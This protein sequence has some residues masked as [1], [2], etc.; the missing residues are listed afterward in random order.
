MALATPARTRLKLRPVLT[1][2][3]SAR[4]WSRRLVGLGIAAFVIF[5]WVHALAPRDTL[6]RHYPLFLL[7]AFIAL[8]GLLYTAVFLEIFVHEAGHWF[9]GRLVGIRISDFV[10]GTGSRPLRFAWRGIRFS[11]GPWLRW[12]YVREIPARANLAF[13]KQ[14]VFLS[15]GMVAVG[16]LVAALYLVPADAYAPEPWL[17]TFATLRRFLFVSSLLG[18]AASA[19]PRECRIEGALTPNDALLIRQA[20]QRRGREDAHWREQEQLAELARLTGAGNY[21][22]A[23]TVL[24]Q[25]LETNPGNQDWREALATSEV[26]AKDWVAVQRR[27]RETIEQAAPGSAER[28]RAIDSAAT[29]ALMWSQREELGWLRP[30]IEQ[31]VKDFRWPTLLGTLGAVLIELG[32]TTKGAEFLHEC[33]SQTDADTDRAIVTAYLA[34][35][36]LRRGEPERARNLLSSAQALGVDHPLVEKLVQELEPELTGSADA[37]TSSE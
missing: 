34:K 17:R 30:L 4:A 2:S 28:A 15:G 29:T 13:G 1:P 23:A 18:L 11:F 14:L 8:L 31:A 5:P 32:E 9:F 33:V 19:F 21:A 36:A 10:V 7:P 24:R 35:A 25:L 26:L 37:L 22:D 6:L 16:L 20:W 3:A 27:H 12:G